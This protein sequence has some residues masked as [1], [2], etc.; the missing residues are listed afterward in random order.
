[1]TPVRIGV[2]GLGNFGEV[3]VRALH[4]MPEFELVGVYSRSAERAAEIAARYGIR[5]WCTDLHDFARDPEIE[6][7]AVVTDVARHAEVACA[8]LGAGKHVF[9][10]K[11]LSARM[12]ETEAVLR[13]AGERKRIVMV[14]YIE[15]Y[16]PRRAIIRDRIVSGD[17]GQIVSLYGR[18]N[19]GR[20]YLQWSRFQRWPLILEPGIHTIAL[21]TWLARSPVRRVYAVGRCHNEWQITDTWWATLEFASGA[22][23]VIEQVWQMPQGN[24]SEFDQDNVLEVIGTQGTVQMRDPTDAFW[25]WTPGSTLSP[26]FYLLPE[27]HGQIVGALRHELAHFAQCIRRN[28]WPDTSLP[29]DIR[30]VTR[31]GLAIVASAE[32][33]RIVEIDQEP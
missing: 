3:H 25:M 10:E 1:M 26:D 6:A 31:V 32:Q 30:H 23:G 14:G 18:R 5:R 8:M 13:L 19:C 27:V 17:L 4:Q 29:D 9:V 20:Q 15:L 16:D 7:V 12:D 24:A 33:R 22:I 2:A 11:P 21:L 28:E